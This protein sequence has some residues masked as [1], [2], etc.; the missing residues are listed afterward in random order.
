M[1]K[2]NQANQSNRGGSNQRKS[3]GKSQRKNNQGQNRGNSSAKRNEAAKLWMQAS[4]Q[5]LS[6]HIPMMVTSGKQTNSRNNEQ[7]NG[8]GS[9][10]KN[11]TRKKPSQDKNKSNKHRGNG[12]HKRHGQPK[13]KN[14]SIKNNTAKS[15]T[16]EVK[17]SST[18][19]EPKSGSSQ[20]KSLVANIDPFELFCAYHLG[21]SADKTYKMAN[22]NQVASRFRVD[23]SVIHQAVKSY[24]MDSASLLDLDF[25]MAL[26]QLDIQVAP[27]GVD[28]LELAKGVYAEFLEAPKVKRD[29]KKMIE[30]DRK[31][32]LKVFG[33]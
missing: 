32:N 28:R 8:N 19:S 17:I 7:P 1:R 10:D 12:H 2:T 25:D 26:A 33:N 31:E 4:S 3:S 5:T 6:S 20:S 23:P 18:T 13:I 22:I 21:I 11:N 29:W 24:G 30:E 15:D 27:E 16:T 14:E 9:P